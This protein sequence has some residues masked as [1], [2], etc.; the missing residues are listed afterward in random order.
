MRTTTTYFSE[1]PLLT[2]FYFSGQRYL[3]VSTRTARLLENNRVFY[4]SMQDTCKSSGC[5]A[6]E[7]EQEQEQLEL[8]DLPTQLE[9]NFPKKTV[10]EIARGAAEIANCMA[11]VGNGHAR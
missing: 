10:A 2:K 6:A 1:L 11:A 9:L 3:K 8:F 7:Q 5:Y 4:F